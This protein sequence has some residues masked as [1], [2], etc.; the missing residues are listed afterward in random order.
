MAAANVAQNVAAIARSA[1][2]FVPW[3]RTPKDK[4]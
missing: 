2:S 1:H 4:W 3:V